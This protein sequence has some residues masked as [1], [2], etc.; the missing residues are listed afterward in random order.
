MA[1][2]RI[3]ERAVGAILQI[4]AWPETAGAAGSMLEMLLG[5]PPPAPG[6]GAGRAEAMLLGLAPGRWLLVAEEAG[7]RQRLATAFANWDAVVTDL[8]AARKR[9]SGEESRE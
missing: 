8:S 7:W 1:E 3:A 2:A 5:A 6:H 9:V 4:G